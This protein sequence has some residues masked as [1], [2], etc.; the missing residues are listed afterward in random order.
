M[1][2]VYGETIKASFAK[3]DIG[4]IGAR[5]HVIPSAPHAIMAKPSD[6]K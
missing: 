2:K 6:F 3:Y 4:T 5:L 1:E